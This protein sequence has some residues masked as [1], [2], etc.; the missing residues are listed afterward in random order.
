MDRVFLAAVVI[1]SISISVISI[2][3]FRSHDN[4]KTRSEPLN[5]VI[6]RPLKIRPSVRASISCFVSP[7]TV[8]T[9]CLLISVSISLLT[10]SLRKL[11]FLEDSLEKE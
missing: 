7:Y 6:F 10:H 1:S 8:F 9:D 5:P 4:F 2:I 3:L 11:C